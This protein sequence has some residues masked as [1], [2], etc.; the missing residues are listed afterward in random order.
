MV[1]GAKRLCF[2]TAG[3]KDRVQPVDLATLEERLAKLNQSVR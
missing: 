2:A 3:W 1:F